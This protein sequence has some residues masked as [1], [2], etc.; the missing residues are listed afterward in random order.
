MQ[1]EQKLVQHQN[2]LSGEAFFVLQAIFHP[3]IQSMYDLANKTRHY[4]YTVNYL[5]SQINSQKYRFL[6]QNHTSLGYLLRYD[7]SQNQGIYLLAE[8]S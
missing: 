8:N 4:S 3:K 7:Q 5:I 2:T 6:E 1:A